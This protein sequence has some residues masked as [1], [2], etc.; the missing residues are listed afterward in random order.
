MECHQNSSD[1]MKCML[2]WRGK[3]TVQFNFVN[4]IMSI[5]FL[6]QNCPFVARVMTTMLSDPK[7]CDPDRP[8][9]VKAALIIGQSRNGY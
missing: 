8:R 2:A 1:A 5:S 3:K 6:I 4:R 7:L 9:S